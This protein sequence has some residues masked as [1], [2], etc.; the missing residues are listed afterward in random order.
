MLGAQI[1]GLKSAAPGDIVAFARKEGAWAQIPVQVDERA[2]VDFCEIY[3]KSSGL[4][5]S[6]PACKTDQVVTALFYTDTE[7]FT[8]ADPDALFDDDD[9]L[10]FMARDAGGRVGTW[11]APA[12]VVAGSA[13]EVEVFEGG[14]KGFVYLF[15]REDTSLDPGAGQ[16]YVS[17]DFS[18]SG[19]IDY[20][21][22]YDLYGYNCGGSICDPSML[23]DSTITGATY[24]YHFAARW[25]S[26]ELR[27]TAGDATGVDILDVHQNR[28]DPDSCGRSV[29]TFSTAE[30]AYVVN[31][32]GPVRALRLYIG[33]NSGPLTQRVHKFYDERQDIVTHLRVH[34]LAAG[35]MDLFDFSTE[36]IGMTYYNS[37][38][39][40]GLTIDGV[41][42]TADESSIQPWDLVTG[43]QGS[44]VMTNTVDTTLNIDFAHFF[45]ADEMSPSFNQCDNSNT[46]DAP[47]GSALGTSGLWLD[48]A[49]AD[50]DPKNGSSDHLMATRTMYFAE[51]NL[52]VDDAIGLVLGVQFPLFTH[53]RS[54]DAET[55]SEPCGDNQCDA[56]EMTSCPMDCQP[57]D[58]SCGDGLCLPPETSTSC[59]Q[60]CP[61]GEAPASRR[62]AT[63]SSTPVP[64]NRS[65]WT[66]SSAL[67]RAWRWGEP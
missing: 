64:T 38:N 58:G 11:E 51:P 42:E 65:V 44:L 7:T 5:N 10:V 56:S 67:A 39:P 16:Q 12:G 14:D 1:P 19:G 48:G 20:K 21:T 40:D 6:S 52:T 3:G 49:L 30:G 8:G 46:L 61:G 60:D 43:E 37:L 13:V 15:E 29:L 35:M 9:E 28:F 24:S 23:E 33:A 55:T 66:W 53:A 36:A 4:W 45:W 54:I 2:V 41:S 32:A 17:Y 18:L 63:D 59:E 27:I 47:D 31:K 57:V 25:V 50:T 34:Q 22:E 26:D 62:R